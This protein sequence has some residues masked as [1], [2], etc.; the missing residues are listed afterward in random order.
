MKYLDKFLKILKTDRN[1]FFAFILILIS[2]YLLIDRI[3]EY[4]LIVFTGVA[5]E[6]WGPISY[7][8]FFASITFAYNLG[9]PSKFMKSDNDKVKWFYTYYVVL[10]IAVIIMVIEWILT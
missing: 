9:V 5:Y 4:L 3:T 6:Y 7:T 1:T 2:I 10:Y 8:L